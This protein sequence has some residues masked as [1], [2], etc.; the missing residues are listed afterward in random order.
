[1]KKTLSIEGM[2]CGH[3]VAR[4]KGALSEVQGVARA[5]VDLG[6]KLAVVEG[7]VLDDA[8]LQAAIAE[9]GYRVVGIS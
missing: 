2:T 7:A 4:V 8:L 6:K 1:M 9:A 3:C 5:E